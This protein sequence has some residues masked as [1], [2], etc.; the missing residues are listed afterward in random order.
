MSSSSL[1]I[2]LAREPCPLRLS[3]TR[4][5]LPLCQSCA[6]LKALRMCSCGMSMTSISNWMGLKT[7]PHYM[8][9]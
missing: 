4:H 2:Q 9:C 5:P 6:W 7:G 1:L 8:P 3:L